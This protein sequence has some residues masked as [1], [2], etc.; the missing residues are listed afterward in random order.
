MFCPSLDCVPFVLFI[1]EGL[2]KYRDLLQLL[3]S[4]YNMTLLERIH[5]PSLSRLGPTH[6]YDIITVD[7]NTAI[8]VQEEQF[9]LCFPCVNS[10]VAQLLLNRAPSLQW[11]LEASHTQ[12]E[13]MFPEITPSV[14]KVQEISVE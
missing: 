11:L 12:L 1:T 10:V 2:L 3:E 4:T 9:L 13:E 8:L 6:L 5:S 14:I 7:E